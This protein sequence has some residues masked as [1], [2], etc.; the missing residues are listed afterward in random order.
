M[1]VN[2]YRNTDREAFLRREMCEQIPVYQGDNPLDVTIEQRQLMWMSKKALSK[3]ERKSL[4]EFRVTSRVSISA[5]EEFVAACKKHVSPF[6]FTEENIFDFIVICK[7]WDCIDDLTREAETF[8]TENGMLPD[9]I[10]YA[11]RDD[12]CYSSDKID[13]VAEE[14][15]LRENILEYLKNDEI[16]AKLMNLPFRVLF[17]A[18]NGRTKQSGDQIEDRDNVLQFISDCIDRR[19]FDDTIGLIMCVDP[20]SLLS[21]IRQLEQENQDQSTEIARL[22]ARINRMHELARSAIH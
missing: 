6:D 7:E 3:F 5:I 18:L 9:F 2:F 12:R 14:K 8:L 11:Y 21:R 4:D 10:E 22:N 15:I 19:G 17:E 20:A 13:T 16:K 1:I